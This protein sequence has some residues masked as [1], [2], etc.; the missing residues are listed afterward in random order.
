MLSEQF[1]MNELQNRIVGIFE[2]SPDM[3]FGFTDIS[4]SDFGKEFK[5]G[6]V[7]AVPYTQ[8]LSLN[9]YNEKTFHEGILGAKDRL[10]VKVGEIEKVLKRDGIRYYVPEVA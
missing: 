4:Y 6:L 10:E 8:Q 5:S 3:I 7:F 9:N 2:D 1:S